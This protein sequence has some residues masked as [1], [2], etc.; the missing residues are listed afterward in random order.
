MLRGVVSFL[1]DLFIVYLFGRQNDG[2]GSGAE[3]ER[4]G[5][6]SAKGRPR[7]VAAWVR[8]RALWVETLCC[9]VVLSGGWPS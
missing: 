5:S 4:C 1:K 8:T 9:V 3:A 6:L 7:Q 2:V